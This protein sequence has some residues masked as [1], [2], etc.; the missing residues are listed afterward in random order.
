MSTAASLTLACAAF[1]PALAASAVNED[2]VNF[3]YTTVT[4]KEGLTF[5][6]P[7]DMPI[8]NRGGIVAPIPF[9]EY[10]YGKFKRMEKRLA[11][12]EARVEKMEKI[13]VL[14]KDNEK[15]S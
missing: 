1:S 6:V 2:D 14:S 12:M 10:A 7:D 5:R 4:T 11:Q 9:D 3:Q 15:K 13:L 8:E